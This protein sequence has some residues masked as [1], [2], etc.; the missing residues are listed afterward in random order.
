MSIGVK[1]VL[2]AIIFIIGVI[3][4]GILRDEI[5]H[6]QYIFTGLEVLALFW[7]WFRN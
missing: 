5:G 4:F 3:G 1:I 7:I 6:G 2:T